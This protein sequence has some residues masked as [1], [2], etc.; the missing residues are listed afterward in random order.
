MSSEQREQLLERITLANSSY[1]DIE[2]G[3]S[4]EG[5]TFPVFAEF[6]TSGEQYVLTKRAKLWEVNTHDY[7]FVLSEESVDE[8]FIKE[9]YTFMTT[10]GLTKVQPGPNHMSSA[11]SVMVLAD[12]ISDA[13]MKMIHK[14]KF[15]KNYLLSFHGWTDLRLAAVDLSRDPKKQIVSNSMGKPLAEMLKSNLQLTD[16]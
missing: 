13:A 1:Y 2:K 15:R 4:F 8:D 12:H 3:H 11:L 7:L 16:K 10:K 6:H 14:A 5:R 9:L